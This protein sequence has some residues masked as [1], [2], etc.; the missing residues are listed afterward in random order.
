MLN[1][2][3]TTC[4]SNH[5]G[6]TLYSGTVT[7]ATH[8]TIVVFI[9]ALDID[10]DIQRNPDASVQNGSVPEVG[11]IATVQIVLEDGDYTVVAAT[12]VPQQDIRE[13]IP[14]TDDDLL[15]LDNDDEE[16]GEYDWYNE[17]PVED[18]SNLDID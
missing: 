1:T 8:K 17:P 15:F 2:E 9:P 18:F 12:F 16:T 13:D 7:T 11:D 5:R 10:V 14:V 6:E 4:Q 3:K